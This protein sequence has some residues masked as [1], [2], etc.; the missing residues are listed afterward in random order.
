MTALAADADGAYRDVTNA[1]TWSSSNLTVARVSSG[2][3]VTT[4]GNGIVEIFASYSGTVASTRVTVAPFPAAPYLS[5]S[6]FPLVN[7]SLGPVPGDSDTATARI[8]QLSGFS[9]NANGPIAWRSSDERVV[10]VTSSGL[11]SA[12]GVGT[13]D[14]VATA[15]GQTGAVRVSILP[16]S[17]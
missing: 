12:I 16:R 10:T 4:V 2:G 9:R 14:I 1:A 8:T 6:V 15:E 5:V 17:R 13:A 3:L 7:T 11:V